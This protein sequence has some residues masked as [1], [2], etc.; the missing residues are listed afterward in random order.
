MGLEVVTK[1]STM[2]LGFLCCESSLSI[3]MW[4]SVVGGVDGEIERV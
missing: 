1:K 2:D 3:F 4:R